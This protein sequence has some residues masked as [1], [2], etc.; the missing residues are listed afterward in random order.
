MT[1]APIGDEPLFASA[2]EALAF[3]FKCTGG[4]VDRPLMCRMSDGSIYSGKGLS[5]TDGATQAGWIRREV[6]ALGRIAEATLIARIATPRLLCA[7]RRPCCSGRK[8]NDEWVDA[9][10]TLTAHAQSTVMRGCIT[11][12]LM[13]REYVVRYFSRKDHKA[14][15]DDISKRH[16]VAINTT[17]AHHARVTALYGG[18]KARSDGEASAPGLEAMA[19]D[20]IDERLRAICMIG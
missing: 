5:G 14:S 3:A 11:N 20:A 15:L 8:D 1:D 16:D 2:Y 18:S 9:I 6:A 19:N 12:R 17:S 10:S 13:C 7:C 4:Y